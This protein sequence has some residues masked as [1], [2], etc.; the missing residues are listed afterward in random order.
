MA[1][2]TGDLAA[3]MANEIIFNSNFPAPII[4]KALSKLQ[5]IVYVTIPGE[6]LDVVM[7][8]RGNASEEEILN[9]YDGKTARY[10][11]EGPLQLG[12]VLAGGN[13][14]ALNRLS[15]YSINV[16]RAFQIRDDILGI[17]GEEKKLGKPVGSDIIEGKQTLLVNKILQLGDKDLKEVVD[18]LLGKKDLTE[19]EL[20]EFKKALMG[21]GAY[22][23]CQNLSK[24][25]IAKALETLDGFEF[26]N[27]ESKMF[28]QGLANYIIERQL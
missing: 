10:T 1:I 14:D 9:M 26:K 15:E 17:F 12:A 4:I 21:S 18:R 6:M 19:E 2:I 3:S 22:D 16:G 5:E 20:E 13:E 11:F 24:K 28:L 8:Y 23:Y 27:E 7:E 25:M